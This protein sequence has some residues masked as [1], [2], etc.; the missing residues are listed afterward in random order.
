MADKI[1]RGIVPSA[2]PLEYNERMSLVVYSERARLAG[3]EFPGS[4]LEM[5]NQI[6]HDK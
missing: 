1:F 4:I 5:A 3:V 2:I 6:V